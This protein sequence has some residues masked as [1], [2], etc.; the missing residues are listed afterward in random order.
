MVFNRRCNINEE[1][2]YELEYKLEEKRRKYKRF[3]I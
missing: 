3:Y 2:I 1:G